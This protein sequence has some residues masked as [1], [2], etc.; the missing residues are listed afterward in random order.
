[1]Y[2]LE[3]F[4]QSFHSIGLLKEKSDHQSHLQTA[5][6]TLVRVAKF[7]IYL[8]TSLSFAWCLMF[9]DA[10]MVDFLD[11]GEFFLCFS[12]III[13]NSCGFQLNGEH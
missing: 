9:A 4:I 2:M 1:M 11:R 13:V 8:S 3:H 10:K 12:I 6:S 7:V 5:N